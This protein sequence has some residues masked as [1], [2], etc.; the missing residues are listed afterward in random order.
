MSRND[1]QIAKFGDER[2]TKLTK[3]AEV[4][5]RTKPKRKSGGI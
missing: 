2:D 3:G 5:K 4:M 1:Y